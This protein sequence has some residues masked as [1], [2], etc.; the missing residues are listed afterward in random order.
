MQVD[1]KDMEFRRFKL[2]PG[3]VTKLH[4][5]I[6]ENELE[7]DDLLFSVGS[8]DPKPTIRAGGADL[9]V[10]KERL[11]HASIATTEE[12]LHTRPTAGETALTALA[13]IRGRAA[14]N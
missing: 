3:I 7:R 12:N 10:V 5:H 9:Q 4:T 1:P 11:G 13:K 14:A 8:D 6:A 2:S